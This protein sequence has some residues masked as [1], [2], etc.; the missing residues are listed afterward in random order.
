MDI[1]KQQTKLLNRLNHEMGDLRDEIKSCERSL[2]KKRIQLEE[3][4]EQKRLLTHYGISA[5]ENA[6]SMNGWWSK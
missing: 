3:L 5:P 4:D 6:A 1:D 2:L